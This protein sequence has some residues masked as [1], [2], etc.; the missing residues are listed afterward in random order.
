MPAW[1][2][3]NVRPPIVS[4]PVRAAMS[5]FAAMLNATV[6]SP[7]PLLPEVTDNHADDEV[8]FQEQP[9][10]VSTLTVLLVA[11]AGTDVLT[12]AIANAQAGALWVTAKLCPPI[13]IDPFRDEVPGFAAN[14]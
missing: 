10:V 5:G 1:L 3:V 8:A 6:P 7:E 2:T 11:A 9:F 14:E 4:V 13:V 12:G